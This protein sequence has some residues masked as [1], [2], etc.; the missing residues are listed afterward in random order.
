MKRYNPEKFI[1]FVADLVDEYD[2]F[3]EQQV[4][5]RYYFLYGGCYELY[6]I[7]NHYFKESQCV[8]NKN[9]KHCAILYNGE[10]F[11][12]TGKV[13]DKEQYRLAEKTDI[14]YMENFFGID[15][16]E[17]KNETIIDEIS[18][19]DIKGKLYQ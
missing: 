18:K 6:K 11:D 14:D 4:N 2:F 12:I 3:L 8:I 16:K 13:K 9:T 17:L 10:I 7:V 5:S 19:C 15:I 1:E